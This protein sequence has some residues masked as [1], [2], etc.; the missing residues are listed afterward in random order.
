MHMIK[1]NVLW[2]DLSSVLVSYHVLCIPNDVF[3]KFNQDLFAEFNIPDEEA[4]EY[5]DHLRS[6]YQIKE[7]D[8]L[9]KHRSYLMNEAVKTKDLETFF[10]RRIIPDSVK[11]NMRAFQERFNVFLENFKQQKAEL[12]LKC[13]DLLHDT[14]D[15]FY[16]AAFEITGIRIP[17][18][19][20]LEVHVVKGLEPSANGGGFAAALHMK[21]I[22]IH[23]LQINSPRSFIRTSIHESMGHKIASQMRPLFQ[24]IFNEEYIYE[25]EE[26]F[27]KT[28]S[29]KIR[30]NVIGGN[31]SSRELGPQEELYPEFHERWDKLEPGTFKEWYGDCLS[32]IK[33]R[34]DS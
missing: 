18:P 6:T 33:E 27:V 5:A 25:I 23:S 12:F 34:L 14:M 7:E 17:T 19:E 1:V 31:P 9:F 16:D 32:A 21:W 8:E 24:E 22:F 26:S 4:R 3:K 30:D 15:R 20:A 28:L 29:K 13:S 11:N 2:D 10:S